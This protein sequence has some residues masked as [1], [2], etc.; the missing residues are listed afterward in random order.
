MGIIAK[1]QQATN[2]IRTYMTGNQTHGSSTPTNKQ[3]IYNLDMY[4]DN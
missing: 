3:Q 2:I 4:L 1:S